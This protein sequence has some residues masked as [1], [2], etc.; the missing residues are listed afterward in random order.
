LPVPVLGIDNV[1]AIAA[2]AHHL[3]ALGADGSVWAWGDNS[4]GQLGNGS[5]I[6][7]DRPMRVMDIIGAVAIAAGG[8][9][10]YAL[11]NDGTVWAWGANGHAQLGDGTVH[12]RRGPVVMEGLID[13]KAIAAGPASFAALRK[14]G[15]VCTVGIS[16]VVSLD[17]SSPFKNAV[18]ITAEQSA[19]Y[20][21]LT[22]GTVRLLGGGSCAPDFANKDLIFDDVR[23]VAAGMAHV[24]FLRDDGTVWSCGQNGSG[25]LG[26]PGSTSADRPIQVSGGIIGATSIAAGASHSLA[27]TDGG[28]WSWGDNSMGQLGTGDKNTRAQPGP[29]WDGT[30]RLR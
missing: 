18:A 24:L 11:K 3:L 26:D 17:C 14:D 12:D 29:L 23:A 19:V 21:L 5:V 15:S 28:I 9:Q 13:V 1:Q 10:S 20:V 22:D 25:Q 4:A 8:D 16:K 6:P 7:A 2:G 30:G 27:V